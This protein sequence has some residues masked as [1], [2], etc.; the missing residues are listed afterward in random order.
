M[1]AIDDD[2]KSNASQNKSAAQEKFLL[3]EMNSIIN[4]LKTLP[5]SAV[6]DV[7]GMRPREKY[8]L[9]LE[10]AQDAIWD[11]K[12]PTSKVI[13]YWSVRGVMDIFA[14]T[15]AEPMATYSRYDFRDTCKEIWNRV[16][17]VDLQNHYRKQHSDVEIAS[18]PS[19]VV[20]NVSTAATFAIQVLSY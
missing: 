13:F 4:M 14:T 2:N 8:F 12:W 16:V 15:S 3:A 17:A 10:E 18:M 7:T 9:S 11:A 19:L 20:N 5:A 6:G 1:Q